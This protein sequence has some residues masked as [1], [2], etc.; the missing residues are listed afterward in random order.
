MAPAGASG[1]GA[2]QLIKGDPYGLP[3]PTVPRTQRE[4][5]ACPALLRIQPDRPANQLAWLPLIARPHMRV[6][7]TVGVAE[8]LQIH[9]AGA[10][11]PS[12]GTP[13]RQPRRAAPFRTR[14]P[15]AC[16][17]A[18]PIAAGHRAHQQGAR[19]SRAGTA[20]RRSREPGIQAPQHGG[21]LTRSAL[22]IVSSRQ[23]ARMAQHPTGLQSLDTEAPVPAAAA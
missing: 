5:P 7:E 2:G 14:R 4:L 6:Q 13:A 21:I 12:A 8:D 19:N 1:H 17:A 16:P 11:G 22:P 3:E 23:S 10:P 9:P 15:S 18:G 20:Y